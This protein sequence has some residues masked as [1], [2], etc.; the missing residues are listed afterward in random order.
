MSV[1]TALHGDCQEYQSLNQCNDQHLSALA[2]VVLPTRK[3]NFLSVAFHK[4]L[5]SFKPHCCYLLRFEIPPN[6]RSQSRVLNFNYF[7]H[8]IT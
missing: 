4:R 3:R 7:K 8:I 6:A 5:P 1:L 2:L